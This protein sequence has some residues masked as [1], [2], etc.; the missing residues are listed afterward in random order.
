MIAESSRP[1]FREIAAKISQ[2]FAKYKNAKFLGGGKYL[3]YELLAELYFD[4]GKEDL[5]KKYVD[6]AVA[7]RDEERQ[8]RL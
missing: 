2:L 1:A 3:I 8:N 4:E 5:A 7:L 6:Q